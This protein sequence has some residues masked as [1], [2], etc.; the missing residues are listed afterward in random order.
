MSLFLP[1]EAKCSKCGTQVKADLASSVNADRRPDLREAILDG[2]FQSMSCPECGTVVRFPAHLTYIDMER[3]QWILVEDGS[4]L[5]EWQE[6]EAE[7]TEL[8]DRSFGKRAPALQQSMGETIKARLVFGWPALKE[9]L[10]AQ[11]AG[12]DDITLELFKISVLRNVP[13]PP[14]ADMTELRLIDTEDDVLTLRW[15]KTVDEEGI[16]DL[17]LERALYDEF[18]SNLTAWAGLRADLEGVLFVDMKRILLAPVA[19][20]A[21]ELV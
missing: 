5:M 21:S 11:A 19:P 15:L 8:Y 7:A 3:D 20:P 6:V 4:R 2:S 1:V 17:P 14:L 18:A 16:N 12:L 9:K 10:L 13:A